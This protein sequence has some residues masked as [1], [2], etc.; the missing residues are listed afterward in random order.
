[1]DDSVHQY[2]RSQKLGDIHSTFFC[3]QEAILWRIEIFRLE[4]EKAFFEVLN[5]A[6]HAVV[7]AKR[8]L[9]VTEILNVM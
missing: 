4:T 9:S 8:I 1:M 6:G 7:I 5:Q 2:F 3:E